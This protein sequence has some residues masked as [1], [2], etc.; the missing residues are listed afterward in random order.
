MRGDWPAARGLWGHV[1]DGDE[2]LILFIVAAIKRAIFGQF[3]FIV[4]RIA[5]LKNLKRCGPITGG[6]VQNCVE[7]S[8]SPATPCTRFKQCRS[9]AVQ[10]SAKAAT[11][12]GLS[13]RTSS[14]SALFSHA[15]FCAASD[16][17]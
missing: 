3:L 1:D 4:E 16:E 14:N 13:R 10:C 5:G 11:S 17:I 12:L 8:I 2:H 9:S 6:M 15:D 7:I